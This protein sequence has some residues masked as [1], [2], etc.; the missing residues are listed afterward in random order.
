MQLL[1]PSIVV[2]LIIVVAMLLVLR[3]WQ[4]RPSHGGTAT[5]EVLPVGQL[6]AELI[7]VAGPL[8]GRRW[9]I[10]ALSGPGFVM[11]RSGD[12]NLSIGGEIATRQHATI[13]MDSGH[14]RIHDMNSANGTYLNGQRISSAALGDGDVVTIGD[15]QLQFRLRAGLPLAAGAASGLAPVPPPVPRPAPAGL[16]IPGFERY[17]LTEIDRGTSAVVLKGTPVGGGD[18]IAVKVLTNADPFFREKFGQEAYLLKHLRHPHIV[19]ELASGL[20]AGHIPFIAMEFCGHGSVHHRLRGQPLPEDLVRLV[21]IHT[22]SALMF[23]HGFGVVHRDIKPANLLFTTPQHV[24]VADFGISRWAQTRSMTVHGTV[25]GTVAYMAPEQA[26]GDVVGPQGDVYSLGVVLYEMLTGRQ[27]F[28]GEPTDVMN[29]H[30]RAMPP[31]LERVSPDLARAVMK[32]LAK[33]PEQ[34]HGSAAAFMQALGVPA[35]PGVAA[36]QAQPAQQP[37]QRLRLVRMAPQGMGDLILTGATTVIGRPQL[38]ERDQQISRRHAQVM[39]Q[40]GIC[41]L[42]DLNSSNGTWI[43][44]QRVTGRIALRAGDQLRIGNSVFRVETG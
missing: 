21:G 11:G 7:A 12:C 8:R 44:H 18:P 25:L 36:E 26:R 10:K 30:V 20:A 27:P 1:S 4:T 23:A 15:S 29:Q 32:A 31:P 39:L 14:W 16:V 6:P 43:N 38:D 33:Q 40:G 3:P 37:P 5:H 41:W 19:G 17:A 35:D 9:E 28:I 22:C 24:K 34:R 2:I 42:E 13:T